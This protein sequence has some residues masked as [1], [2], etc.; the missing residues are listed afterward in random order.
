MYQYA[1]LLEGPE[2]NLY[3]QQEFSG[4]KEARVEIGKVGNWG[5]L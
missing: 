3:I 2:E 1:D 5:Q 4:D